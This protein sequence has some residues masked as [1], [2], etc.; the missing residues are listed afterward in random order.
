VA[1][2]SC[3]SCSRTVHV[4]LRQGEGPL[5]RQGEGQKGRKRLGQQ[6]SHVTSGSARY[7]ISRRNRPSKSRPPVQRLKMQ[8]HIVKAKGIRRLPSESLFKKSVSSQMIKVGQTCIE[9]L[10][11]TEVKLSRTLEKTQAL[12]TEAS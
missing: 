8:Q 10:V 12:K 1:A 3:C 4:L 7:T 11:M 9:A 5:L 2:I 6:P